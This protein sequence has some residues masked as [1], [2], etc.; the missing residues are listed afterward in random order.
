MGIRLL[1]FYT[2]REREGGKRRFPSDGRT[3]N[4]SPHWWKELLCCSEREITRRQTGRMWGDSL[5]FLPQT[6]Q[7]TNADTEQWDSGEIYIFCTQLAGHSKYC[8]T[9]ASRR[10]SSDNTLFLMF[11]HLPKYI[12]QISGNNED[13]NRALSD[14]LYCPVFT[15]SKKWPMFYILP[16]YHGMYHGTTHHG[17]IFLPTYQG[18]DLTCP[19]PNL[20]MYNLLKFSS[21]PMN[22]PGKCCL[23]S[24]VLI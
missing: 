11:I 10:Y 8:Q 9:E 6:S 5:I 21:I 4:K 15:R 22:S 14:W 24:G 1:T 7:T 12:R 3:D 17:Q 23:F 19:R 2:G 18:K 13:C 16:W 20:N